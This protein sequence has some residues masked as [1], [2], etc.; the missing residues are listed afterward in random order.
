MTHAEAITTGQAAAD[1]FGK[2][3]VVYR[4]PAWPVGVYGV[5]AMANGLPREAEKDRILESA[6]RD[7]RAN[8]KR[9]PV[10]QGRL[11]E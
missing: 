10:P 4:L 9:Q 7:G 8:P 6:Q 11:F 2:P 1:R 5:Q 3:F